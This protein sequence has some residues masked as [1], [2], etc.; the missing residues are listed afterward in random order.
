MLALV[1]VVPQAV[2][3]AK[4]SLVVFVVQCKLA[5]VISR[6]LALAAV[7]VVLQAVALAQAS[8]VVSVFQC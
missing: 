8:F 3:L 1:P 7:P 2:A 5:V 6:V 4:A